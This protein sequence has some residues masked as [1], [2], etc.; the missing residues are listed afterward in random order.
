MKSLGKHRRHRGFTLIELLLVLA[1]VGILVGLLMPACHGTRGRGPS[2]VCLNNLKQLTLGEI[3][4]A[5]DRGHAP[6][7]AQLSTNVGGLRE[8]ALSARLKDYYKAISNEVV[9]PRVFTC[10]SNR[11]D[12]VDEFAA[13]TTNHLSYFLNADATFSTNDVVVLHGD[14]QIEFTPAAREAVHRLEP[15]TKL[16]WA[17]GIHFKKDQSG[18]VAHTDGGVYRVFSKAEIQEFFQTASQAGHR[19]VLP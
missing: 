11:L 12:P 14:R 17:K 9:S 18:N 19:I 13:L 2:I 1:T 5:N 8:I 4:W 7:P 6:L 15:N 3:V 10:P 16:G